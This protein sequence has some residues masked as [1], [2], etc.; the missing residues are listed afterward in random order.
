MK[1]WKIVAI[2]T[3]ITLLIA[4][5]YTFSVWKKRQNPGAVNQGQEQK[6]IL[7]TTW[8]AVPD[9]IPSHFEDL[10]DEEG[11]TV[12]MKTAIRCP[13]LLTRAARW[14]LRSALA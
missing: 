5:I 10:K 1:P 4:G 14:D 8:R 2:P 9:Q 6:L 13:T 7:R 3:L 11:K 12:W